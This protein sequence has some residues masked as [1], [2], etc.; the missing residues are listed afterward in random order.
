MKKTVCV[1]TDND[2]DVTA[3]KKKY[4]SYLDKN[5]K[6]NINIYY[7]EVVD[8]GELIIG[9][10]NFNYN[11]LEPKLLKANSLEVLNKVLGVKYAQD[12]ELHIHMRNNKTDCALKVFETK[13]EINYPQYI[14]DA[15]K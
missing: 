14:L 8:E 1:V 6:E 9:K 5:K 12:D 15:I 3:L 7:D 2:G 13:E 10:K 11:T 4:A